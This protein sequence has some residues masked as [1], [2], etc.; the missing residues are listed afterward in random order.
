MELTQAAEFLRQRDNYIIVT[1]RRPDGDTLGSAAGLCHALRRLGK[2]AW[3]YPN[4]DITELF[5]VYV[6]PYIAPEGY[7]WDTVVAAD[8]ADSSLI[9]PGFA[10][11]ID[12][13]LDHHPTRGEPRENAVIWSFKASCGELILSL[14]ELLCGDIDKEEADL[15]YIAVSTD[16]GCFV[17][18]NTKADTHRAAARLMDAGADLPLLNKPLFRFKSMARILLEGMI[19]A[20]MRS[21]RDGQISVAVATL[22]M[23]AKSGATED[24]CNDLASLAGQVRGNKAAITVRELRADPPLSKVSIRTDGIVDAS[25]ICALF[26]GGG[27][28]MA[29]GCELPL[30][31]EE[32]AKR[33]YE[34]VE[35]AWP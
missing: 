11:E 25:H 19:C 8:I 4:P 24:D 7:R 27:H 1:H 14:I 5:R 12:L 18:D 9:C 35:E 13:W 20:D 21:F 30:P 33:I 17:Y 28:K 15:L 31:P 26:G 2:T 32:T 29:A 23:F 16:T 34:A 10:G 22:D 6:E 3:L